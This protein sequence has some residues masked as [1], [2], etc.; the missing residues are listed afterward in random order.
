MLGT[1]SC[2]DNESRK[3]ES[4]LQGHLPIYVPGLDDL[5]IRNAGARRLSFTTSTKE[6]VQ[7]GD[8][9]FIAVPTPPQTDGSVDSSFI[10]KVAREIAEHLTD[11]RVIV[12]KSTVPVR[13]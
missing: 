6:G 9:V 8:M 13:T 11:C 5:I 10:E 1:M 12:D 3:I 4:L 7:H 2:V